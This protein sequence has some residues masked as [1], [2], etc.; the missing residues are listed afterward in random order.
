M[1][2]NQIVRTVCYFTDKPN[3]ETVDKLDFLGAKITES[4]YEVQTKRIC[5]PFENPKVLE[6]KIDDKTIPICVGSLSFE[7]ILKNLSNFYQAK[8]V[9]FNTDLTTETIKKDHSEIVFVLIKNKP[10]MTFNFTYVFNNKPS[11]PYFPSAT[12][13]KNGFAIGL[14]PTDLSQGCTTLNEWLGKIKASWETLYKVFGTD[15]EFLGIDSSIAPIF[16]G[17]GSLVHF[18][19]RLGMSFSESTTTDTY[20]T[21]TEF[22]KKC[23]PKPIGLCGL[24]MPCLE[25]FELANEYEQGNFSIERN[26]FLSLHSGLGID[27]YPIGTDENPQRVAQILQLIQRLSN[28]YK[29]PLSAR[30]VS[31]GKAKIGEK[32]NFENK[33]LKDITVRKL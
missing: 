31:D 28:K 12:Y 33:Y 21:I 8:T 2:N 13:Q 17:K 20:V 15:T 1:R 14:Q 22:I 16:G 23:N 30:F 10:S 29:K 5:S 11:S 6:E 26:I 25:D 3:R 32:T 24:M 9:F 7:K 4:G 27:T 19:K 18:I